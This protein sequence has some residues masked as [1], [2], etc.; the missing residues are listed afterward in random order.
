MSVDDMNK[1]L[2]EQYKAL[3]MLTQQ[4]SQVQAQ[5]NVRK[6]GGGSV[7]QSS[8]LQ[9]SVP[10]PQ[11]L[12]TDK[13]DVRENFEFFKD[14]W[15]N[16]AIA[17]GMSTWPV[18]QEKQKISILLAAIGVQAMKKYLNFQ[19][20]EEEKDT[21]ENVLKLIEARLTTANKNVIYDRY[22]FNTAIQQQDESFDNYLI[23]L[24][25]LVKNC[26]YEQFQDDL[27]RDRIVVGIKD[28]AL[29][30]KLMAKI[31]LTLK[32]ATKICRVHEI[33][34]K[35]V[36]SM[37]IDEKVLSTVNKINKDKGATNKSKLCRYCGN[38][39]A[40]VK[41]ACPAFGKICKFC[42]K[43][44]HTEKVCRKKRQSNP[45]DGSLV[46]N[47]KFY[48]NNKWKR[49]A[50]ELDTGARSC[51]MGYKYYCSIVDESHRRI[52][53]PSCF[54][55]DF[56]K[57]NIKV[58]GETS[59]KFQMQN[60]KNNGCAETEAIV[61]KYQDVFQGYGSLPGVTQLEIDETV[62]PVIQK[63]EESL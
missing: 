56:G 30:R 7:A 18:T 51:V 53:Q 25:K 43:K 48:I 32:T 6:E 36:N 46:A 60:L 42:K 33:T 1:I 22:L 28:N 20:T 15:N 19:L 52:Q 61:N 2:T 4:M 17:T 24:K 11:P 27:L 5:L 58:L 21:T 10:W 3:Q 23:R 12:E 16:Y 13:G 8:N 9:A 45:K 37:Q 41:G 50:C 54:L 44:N 39:H 40:F 14:S 55:M 59:L 38:A 62:K 47:I 31:D 26:E 35:Q 57:H 29:K 63:H 34:E 49:I